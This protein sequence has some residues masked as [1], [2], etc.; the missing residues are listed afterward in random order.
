MRNSMS[1]R[2]QAGASWLRRALAPSR[3]RMPSIPASPSTTAAFSAA[4]S[5]M[6]A[7]SS[8]RSRSGLPA[9]CEYTTPLENP[10]S[11]AIA[12]S[13]A[14]AYP[15]SR[16][17]RLAA[18][19]TRPRL[20]WTCSG[21]DSLVAIANIRYRWYPDVNGM[22]ILS[23]ERLVLGA[24]TCP[25]PGHA[26]V[27]QDGRLDAEL[28]VQRSGP[29][30]GVGQHVALAHAGAVHRQRPG[31]QRDD[32]VVVGPLD[33]ERLHERRVRLAREAPVVRSEVVEVRARVA[34]REVRDRPPLV[35]LQAPAVVRAADGPAHR[36]GRRR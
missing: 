8:A 15:R 25:Q 36:A 4:R 26:I 30:G 6:R 27:S 23:E 32:A 20:R 3:T 5:S 28:V 14:P 19:S 18:S 1:S 9:N 33:D 34:E 22:S 31:A 10:A 2:D 21:R 12:S 16:K 11:S 35:L 17:T 13:V 24:R 29:G 7:S